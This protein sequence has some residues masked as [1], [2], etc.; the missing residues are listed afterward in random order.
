[1]STGF[2]VADVFRD[3]T[4]RFEARYG[5]MVSREQRQVIRA[6]TRCRTAAL[7][8]HVYRCED[9]G[10]EKIQYNSCRNRHCPKCQAMARSAWLAQRESELLP[11]PYFHLV[12]TIP[13]ELAPLALQNKRV[14][15]GIL[16]QAAAQ[17]VT[18]LAADPKHLGATIGCL[19]VLH[20]WGQNLMHHPHLHAIVSGGGISG[21]G[22]RWVHCKQSKKSDKKFLLPVRVLSAVFRGKFIARLKQAF[23]SCQLSFHGQLQGDASPDAFETLLRRATC[24]DWVVYAKR[25]F[26]SP[27]CVL[28]YLARYTHRVAISN[29]RLVDIYDG[30]VRFRYKDYADA[31]QTKIMKLSTEEF[32]RRFLMHTLPAGFVRIRYYGFLANRCRQRQLKRCRQLLGVL[33]AQEDTNQDPPQASEEPEPAADAMRCPICKIGLLIPRGT[34]LPDLPQPVGA[35]HYLRA[36]R[37][38]LAYNDSS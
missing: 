15:Y 34:L 13:H 35:P 6:V 24:R 23:A 33:L 27:N 9:C 18:Q 29:Q 28:K 21:D 31:Q 38:H 20:T 4:A 25:P 17:T 3:A 36:T 12:F 32:M 5:H 19:I 1:M 8:G 22:T 14:V 7:G 37:P 11:I 26:S 10:H 16:F 30:C 2:E